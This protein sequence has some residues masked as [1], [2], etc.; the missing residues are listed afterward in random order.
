[1]QRE[2]VP[3]TWFVGLGSGTDASQVEVEQALVDAFNASHPNILLSL[4]VVPYDLAHEELTNRMAAGAAPDIVGPVGVYG[5]NDFRGQWLDLTSQIQ[6]SDF[7]LSGYEPHLVELYHTEEGQIAIPFAVYPAATYYNPALFDEAGLMYPPVGVGEPYVLDGRKLE[8]SWETLGEVARILTIDINGSNATSP[9]F[10][11]YAVYQYGYSP[12]WENHP[13]YIG[14]FWGSGSTYLGETGPSVAA[15]PEAWRAA[16]QWY[17]DGMWGDKPFI[18][19]GETAWSPDFGSGNTFASGRIAM[20]V[21]M[22]WYLC[23][24]SDLTQAG[25]TFDLAALPSYEGEVHGR[26]DVDTFHIWKGTPHPAEAFEV[27]SYLV[28]PEGVESLI[29][30][31]DGPPVFAGLS[32]RPEYHS[33][34]IDSQAARY[35]DVTAWEVFLTGLAF[36]DIP[37]AEAYTPN[38]DEAWA[39]IQVFGD[40]IANAPDLDL[41]AEIALLESDLTTIF[42]R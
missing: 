40:L 30:G 21:N 37:H 12:V 42:N 17:Y 11:R 26:V 35:P 5:S 22:L 41:Q 36:P 34:Y 29:V 32:A 7:D 27:L 31:I 4:E 14:S 38:F 8:W 24:L 18:P 28:G 10:D 16:W 25:W 20:S 15:I 3:I 23:C 2:P 13:S 1:M 6:S 33:A 9:D 19:S 39:R